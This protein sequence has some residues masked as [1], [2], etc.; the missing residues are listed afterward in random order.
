[1]TA[2]VSTRCSAITERPR[3]MV[4]YN[5]KSGRLELGSNVLR[6]LYVYLQP[7]WYNRPENLSNSV[8]KKPKIRAIIR[9]LLSFKVIEVGTNRE[10]KCDFL[11]VINSNWH[12]ISY[13]IGVIAAYCSNFGHF[14]FSSHPLGGL[15]T[16][17]DVHLGLNGKRVVDFLL[18]LIE[19]FARCY[20]WVATSEKIANRRFHSNAVSLIQN[21]RQKGLPPPIIFA[22][23][24]R[25]MNAL[26]LCRW[27]FSHKETL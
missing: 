1:M 24:V 13:S 27:Q 8:K 23:I 7:L 3:C 12:P 21:F 6:T 16:M 26:Q 15:G 20:G 4:C 25:L 19:L 17:Y 10:P 5:A 18:V 14:A 22:R 9:R 11:L 2:R